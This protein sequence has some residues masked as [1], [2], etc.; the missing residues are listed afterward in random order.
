MQPKLKKIN[1]SG[2]KHSVG[3]KAL[4][5]DKFIN[6]MSIT[7]DQGSK[8]LCA[9]YYSSNPD[10]SKAHKEYPMLSRSGEKVYIL[11][12]TKEE[13]E[14]DRVHTGILCTACNTVLVSLYS[15]D[16][17]GCGCS[18][19]TCIDGGQGSYTRVLGKDLSKVVDVKVDM[20]N[21]KFRRL[22]RA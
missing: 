5:A 10:I 2:F 15:H 7:N 11:A 21:N 4:K 9:V 19:E 16:F 18:N 13:L 17:H 20:I 1:Y 22:K 3:I 8:Q 6:Y 12:R 14:K